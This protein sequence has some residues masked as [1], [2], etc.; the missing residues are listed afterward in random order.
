MTSR[1]EK[2]AQVVERLHAANELIYVVSTTGCRY[3]SRGT[4]Y[5]HLEIDDRSQVYLFDPVTGFRVHAYRGMQHSQFLQIP[6]MQKFIQ[7]LA[8][9]V[10]WGG[11]LGLNELGPWPNSVLFGDPWG[12]GED[13]EKI[14]KFAAEQGVYEKG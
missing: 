9:Y 3:F 5:A 8:R 12:Y 6:H 1:S 13:M 10:R 11:K 2:F 14:R 4:L 7:A